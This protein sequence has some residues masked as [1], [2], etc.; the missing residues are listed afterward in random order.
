MSYCFS[1][2]GT[3]KPNEMVNLAIKNMN[4]EDIKLK[5]TDKELNPKIKVISRA[6]NSSTIKKLKTAGA[7]NVIMPDKIGGEH[8]ASLLI[9][10]DLVEFIDNIVLEGTKKINVL[11]IYTDKLS[12]EFIGKKLEE[13]K[14]FPK[15]GC[16]IV[17]Y[18]DFYG[19]YIINPDER[20]LI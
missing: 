10:P 9:T 3:K 19:E 20:K 5:G 17:G 4:D 8:M 1:R 6:S 14:I 16:K 15:T 7:E 13:L 11:E 18:K 12:K 2:E